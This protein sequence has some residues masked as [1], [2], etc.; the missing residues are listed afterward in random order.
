MNKL[1]I[2][3]LFGLLSVSLCSYSQLHVGKNQQYQTIKEAVLSA[4]SFDTLI[5]HEGIYKEHS[6]VI[7]KP[8]TLIAKGKAIIDAGDAVADIFV[9]VSDSVSITGFELINVGVSFLKEI[10]A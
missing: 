7:N 4:T 5:I 6:L 1:Y 2:G 9:I 3:M 8:L 10:A